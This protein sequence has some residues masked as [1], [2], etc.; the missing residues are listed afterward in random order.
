MSAPHEQART[1]IPTSAGRLLPDGRRVYRLTTPLAVWWIW[2]GLAVLS[3]GDLIIQGHDYLSVKFALGMLTVT[4]LVFACTLWSKVI[5]D[6]DG[7]TVRNPFRV[8]T[9]PWAAVRGIFL[10]DSVEI[11]CSRGP[12]KKDKT[13]YTWALSSTRRTRA[14]AKLHGWQWEQGKRSR[15]ASYGQLPGDARELVKM[16]PTEVMA[17]EMAQLNE[18]ARARLGHHDAGRDQPERVGTGQRGRGAG[19]RS[20]RQRQG[21]PVPGRPV[22]GRPVP[23][24]PAPGL[25]APGGSGPGSVRDVHLGLAR[26]GR[27]PGAGDRVR[28]R[29]GCWLASFPATCTAGYAASRRSHRGAGGLGRVGHDSQVAGGRQAALVVVQHVQPGQD[30]PVPGA[31]P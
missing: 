22:P 25:P 3:L 6:D 31:R 8:F 13:V 12:Q 15:P 10:A 24:R 30:I 18:N 19:R 16:S 17:R 28:D 29:A 11:Q 4:G 9:I 27:D 21:R 23:G 26:A 7:I 2:V 5:A 20:G 14:R 1:A